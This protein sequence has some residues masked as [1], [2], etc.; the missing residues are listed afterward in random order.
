MSLTAD[1][2]LQFLPLLPCLAQFHREEA[3]P[4]WLLSRYA[5]VGKL[6]LSSSQKYG[7]L[8]MNP[9]SNCQQW[10]PQPSLGSAL[11]LAFA[12]QNQV[13]TL[14]L[15][16]P[17]PATCWGMESVEPEHVFSLAGVYVNLLTGNQLLIKPTSL[18]QVLGPGASKQTPTKQGSGSRNFSICPTVPPT[19]PPH[20]T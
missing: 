13:L 7:L 14:V 18:C 1:Q 4:G 3:G 9:W 10:P 6:W 17:D 8:L 19:S 12:P 16:A 5:G 11:E 20:R 15:T 2:C